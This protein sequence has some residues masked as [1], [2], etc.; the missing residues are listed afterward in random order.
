MSK[1]HCVSAR[2]ASSWTH[3]PPSFFSLCSTKSHDFSCPVLQSRNQDP[4]WYKSISPFFCF[5]QHI[6]WCNHRVLQQWQTAQL[7]QPLTYGKLLFAHP[8]HHHRM[9]NIRHL[10]RPRPKAFAL[11]SSKSVPTALRIFLG[12]AHGIFIV[13]PWATDFESL[14]LDLKLFWRRWSWGLVKMC[15]KKRGTTKKNRATFNHSVCCLP[16]HKIH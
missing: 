16:T 14:V 15:L 4:S 3:N 10:R 2:C 11:N 5:H 6:K 9:K 12:T 8:I 13:W 1:C 7:L